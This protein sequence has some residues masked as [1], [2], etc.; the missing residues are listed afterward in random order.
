MSRKKSLSPQERAREIVLRLRKNYPDAECSLRFSN[1]FELIIATILSAQCT[2]ERVNK[3]TPALFKKFPNPEKMAKADLLEIEELIRSTGFFKNKAKS[4]VGC[5]KKLVSDFNG[6]VP[7]EMEKLFSLPGVGRKTAN[8]V[9]GNAFG[10]PG[11]VVDTH[12]TRISNLLK[13]AKGK[14]AVKLEK[15]LE[16]VIEKADWIDYSH[17]LIFHGRAI[18]KARNPSCST[19]FLSDLCPSREIATSRS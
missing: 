9:L 13:L 16:K 19:C 3:V 5:A 10:I 7:Q 15:Q 11:M 17:L 6:E 8:V 4:L 12:V 18:C 1:P 2:D 14:D